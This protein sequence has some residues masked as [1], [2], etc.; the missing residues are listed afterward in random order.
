MKTGSKYGEQTKNHW[1]YLYQPSSRF[2]IIDDAPEPLSK[3]I[4]IKIESGD[5]RRDHYIDPEHD[6][7]RVRN[8]WWKQ[9]DDQWEKESEYITIEMKQLPSGQW[10]ESKRKL[11][12]YPNPDRGTMGREC[13][14]IIDIKLLEA[15]EF[16]LDTFNGEKLLEG[17]N[18]ETH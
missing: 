9:R 12:T 8:I 16:P 13:N 5:I 1:A 17:A 15:D 3:Y 14:F 4:G 11:I 10:Y 6:Y 18:L 7:I 2:K